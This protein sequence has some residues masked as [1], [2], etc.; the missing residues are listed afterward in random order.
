MKENTVVTVF[1]SSRPH[2]GDA[3]YEHA[4]LAG[5]ILAQNGYTV[6]NGGYGGIM[7][8]SARGAKESG[9]KTIGVVTSFF[10]PR[11]NKWIDTTIVEK[12]LTGRLM[13]LIS[14]GDAYLILKGGTGTLLEFAAV[15]EFMNKNVMVEKP[16]IVVGNFWERVVET[17]RSELTFEGKGDCSRYVTEV[18]S[19][20]DG[21][22]YLNKK[23]AR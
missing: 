11:A 3:D 6:C 19:P 12:T 17:M 13:K 16:I 9:G 15:W 18:S 8:A 10:S 2:E 20:E 7:E 22:E 1:G 23:L 5:K 21:A 14:L 4:R